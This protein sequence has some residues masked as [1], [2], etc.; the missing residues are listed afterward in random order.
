MAMEFGI[1][2]GSERKTNPAQELLADGRIIMGKTLP[3]YNDEV[4][5][6]DLYAVSPNHQE[7]VIQDGFQ[8]IRISTVLHRFGFT[9][10][11]P[12]DG[13]WLSEVGRWQDI[14]KRILNPRIKNVSDDAAYQRV[15]Y[16]KLQRIRVDPR[17]NLVTIVQDTL[18]HE[19]QHCV[20][21]RW[22]AETVFSPW[23]E[24]TD[25]IS[26]I[27]DPFT[28]K[29]RENIEW[30]TF[31][32]VTSMNM[33]VITCYLNGTDDMGDAFHNTQLGGPP[34]VKFVG[35]AERGTVAVFELSIGT[36]R[37]PKRT[38][39]GSRPHAYLDIH[40]LD[41]YS[42]VPSV[43]MVFPAVGMNYSRIPE[44]PRI[45]LRQSDIDEWEG[46]DDDSSGIDLFG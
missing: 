44:L 7:K 5:N 45:K 16:T 34:I 43:G 14:K 19:L 31:G 4:L 9:V 26:Q 33:K 24:W 42:R 18:N 46:S 2:E 30:V 25:S 22:L 37:C 17:P 21:F 39:W 1:P 29:N 11:V 41:V 28:V 38:I 20:D 13:E 10:T 32:G 12:P 27:R 3:L 6:K 40:D 23:S 36:R 8:I 15:E 35:T